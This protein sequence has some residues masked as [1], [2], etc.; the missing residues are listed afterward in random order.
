MKIHFKDLSGKPEPGVK[1]FRHLCGRSEMGDGG[2]SLLF[3][4]CRMKLF[5]LEVRKANVLNGFAPK[6]CLI[7]VDKFH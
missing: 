2:F 6:G 1:R 5:S 4:W 7:K 3:D